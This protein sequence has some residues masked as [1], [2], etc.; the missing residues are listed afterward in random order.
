MRV[1]GSRRIGVGAL[2]G[3][4]GLALGACG[5][6]GATNG[7]VSS[8]GANRPAVLSSATSSS[9]CSGPT[10]TATGSAT[11]NVAPNLLTVVLGV[12]TQ[13]ASAQAA[14][15]ANNTRARAVIGALEK[16]GVAKSELQTTGLS[17]EPTYSHVKGKPSTIDGYRVDNT[18]T[19]QVQKLSSDGTVIDR[20]A[21]QVG[22]GVSL[23]GI[24]FSLQN[25][26]S[27]V[28]TA[29][30][31]A[32]DA[33]MAEA[34]AMAGAS[35]DKLGP[36]CSVSDQGNGNEDFASASTASAASTGSAG[37][38]SVPVES[39]TEQV[40]AQVKVVYALAG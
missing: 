3:V 19:V 9:S 13:A 15:T 5:T 16:A 24:S 18:V 30:T 25:D 37:G 1:K 34:Q 33:G 38:G 40:S 20:A 2:V 36:L 27:A 10:V 35:G 29:H 23:E 28:A 21:T 17:I 4:A 7:P 39:G 26:N 14:L 22:D 32:V 12:D 8:P 31:Q 11:T 6:S